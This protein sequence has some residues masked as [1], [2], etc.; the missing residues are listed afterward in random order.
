MIIAACYQI[1]NNWL[2]LMITL[3]GHFFSCQANGA[4]FHKDQMYNDAHSITKMRLYVAGF[5]L[6]ILDNADQRVQQK[7]RKKNYANRMQL[8][9]GCKLCNRKSS[10]RDKCKKSSQATS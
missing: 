10:K 1:R 6:A 3:N 4:E 7:Q 2:L 9:N 5:H 8:G